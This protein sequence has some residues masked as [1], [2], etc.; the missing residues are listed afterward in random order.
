[1]ER[2]AEIG[3]A[4]GSVFHYD[5]DMVIVERAHSITS[6]CNGCCFMANGKDCRARTVVG[7]CKSL[8]RSDQ[9]NVIFKKIK[10]YGEVY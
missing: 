6:P 8:L 9:E 3:R 5:R 10:D 7:Y 4:I 2:Q 1:M